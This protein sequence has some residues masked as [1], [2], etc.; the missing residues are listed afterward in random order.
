MPFEA[1]AHHFGTA[2]PFLYIKRVKATHPMQATTFAIAPAG[3]QFPRFAFRAMPNG[4]VNCTHHFMDGKILRKRTDTLEDATAGV[5][6]VTL[7]GFG[8]KNCPAMV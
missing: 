8:Y 4:K 3:Q 1:L 2:L 5:L 6:I 7:R